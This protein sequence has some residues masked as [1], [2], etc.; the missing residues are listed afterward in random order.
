MIAAPALMPA[1]PFGANPP[2]AGLFQLIGLIRVTPT[3]TKK[4]MIP[5]L[6]ITIALFEL[7]DS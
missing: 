1:K 3:A 7:A 4:R 5:I 6:R 2:V